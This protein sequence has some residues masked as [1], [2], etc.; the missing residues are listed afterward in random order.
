MNGLGVGAFS[1]DWSTIAAF[2]LS[3]LVSPFFAIVNV[4]VGYA[5]VVYFAVPL[6][7]WGTNMYNANNFPIFSSD[8]FDA[9]GQSYNITAIVNDRFEL[10]HAAYEKNGQ[11]H[12]SLFFA[13]SFHGFGFATIAS[14]ITHVS[15]FY[16]RWVLSSFIVV[17]EGYWYPVL[18]FFDS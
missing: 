4:L 13:L 10:D 2:L 17:I 14:T 15:L 7:Y 11:I 18:C 8:L 16:G 3:P 6:A 9:Q 1:L 12:M 5:L